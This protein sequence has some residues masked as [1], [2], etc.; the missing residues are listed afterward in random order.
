M[1]LQDVVG[2]QPPSA[3]VGIVDGREH[4][5]VALQEHPEGHMVPCPILEHRADC[6]YDLGWKGLGKITSV[7]TEQSPIFVHHF[8]RT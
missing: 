5:G 7:A 6:S 1:A 2:L 4:I 8:F 3:Q